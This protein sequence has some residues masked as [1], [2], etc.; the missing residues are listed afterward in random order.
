ML[1]Y[2]IIIKKI[3]DNVNYYFNYSYLEK[4]II[5]KYNAK[6]L[7]KAINDFS[8]D[9]H[10]NQYRIRDIIINH[11]VCFNENEIKTSIDLLKLK[12]EEVIKCF[13]N[14]EK[15]FKTKRELLNFINEEKQD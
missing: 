2:V 15:S 10:S 12:P 5:E 8:K 11:K 3:G 6:T 13:F 9:L 14:I 1:F 7:L 4:K